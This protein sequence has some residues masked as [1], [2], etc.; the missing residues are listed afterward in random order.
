[1]RYAHVIHLPIVSSHSL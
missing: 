1:M